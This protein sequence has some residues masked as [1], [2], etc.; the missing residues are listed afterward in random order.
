[1]L[2][3]FRYEEIASDLRERIKQKEY[4]EDVR[5]P[6][7]R[8][9]MRQ[10]AVQR[11]TL[12]KALNVLQAEGILEIRPRSG[13]FVVA[14]KTHAAPDN[15]AVLPLPT[16]TI[17]VINS[18][19][20]ASMSLDKIIVGLTHFLKNTPLDVARFNS[21]PKPGSGRHVMPTREY[22]QANSVVGVM[23]W[24]QSSADISSLAF[25]RSAAPL[26]LIDRRVMGFEADSVRFDDSAGGRMVTE[27][28][29]QQGHRR[30]GFLGDEVFVETVQQRWRGYTQALEAAHIP[31]DHSRQALFEGIT[32][33]LFS[34]CMR[35][36]IAGNGSP[37]TAVVCSNDLVALTLLRFLQKEGIEVPGTVAITGYGNVLTDYLEALELT[38][39]SQSFTELG[40]VAGQIICDRL[41]RKGEP[42]FVQTELPVHLIVRNSS[43]CEKSEA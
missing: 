28:L 20:R 12:R 23:V 10:Y 3:L 8:V 22:L 42:G 40:R 7:E 29:I 39:V 25:L 17:L 18:W 41:Q 19:N 2:R 15:S 9:L 36:F 24:P 21:Q 14:P 34:R 38:T 31:L 27:H 4:A 33:P 1:M 37:L 13:V 16:G 6:A 32:E 11:N 5:L 35:E 43:Q 30:I 26:V